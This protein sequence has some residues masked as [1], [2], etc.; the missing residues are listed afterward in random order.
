M[1]QEQVCPLL[2]KTL[3]GRRPIHL[4]HR[5]TVYIFNSGS[6]YLAL[7]TS[8][9]QAWRNEMKVY[10]TKQ[11]QCEQDRNKKFH[12]IQHL[13]STGELPEYLHCYNK[14]HKFYILTRYNNLRDVNAWIRR[15]GLTEEMKFKAARETLLALKELHLLGFVSR[16]VKMDNFGVHITQDN[17]LK[18]CI[19]DFELSQKY[20]ATRKSTIGHGTTEYAPLVQMNKSRVFSFC[21]FY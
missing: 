2:P 4:G 6:K 3:Y 18:F 1:G 5:S 19:Y 8:T 14:Q 13:L 11:K 20:E 12:R 15:S 10:E 17:R 16:D 21:Y 9:E 7:K